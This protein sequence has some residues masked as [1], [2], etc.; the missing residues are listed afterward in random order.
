MQ[1]HPVRWIFIKS[2]IPRQPY[3]HIRKIFEIELANSKSKNLSELEKEELI[4]IRERTRLI[5]K[6][7]QRKEATQNIVALSA[8]MVTAIIIV[9]FLLKI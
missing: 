4:K 2:P 6:Q 1:V 5:L 9:Y 3:T 7:K 8:V